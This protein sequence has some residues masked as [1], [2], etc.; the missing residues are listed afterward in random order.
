MGMR[1][2]PRMPEWHWWTPWVRWT[3]RL[4]G[5][6]LGLG[7]IFGIVVLAVWVVVG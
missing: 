7:V 3:I 1:P 6:A 2:A 4:L 5:I